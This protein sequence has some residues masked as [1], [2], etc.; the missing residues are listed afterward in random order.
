MNELT[1]ILERAAE[2]IRPADA[3]EPDRSDQIKAAE[4]FYH[5]PHFVA[6]YQRRARLPSRLVE[7][8]IDESLLPDAVRA[9]PA[10]IRAGGS[11]LLAG[12]SGSG[13]TVSATWGVR[14]TYL[15]GRVEVTPYA[16]GDRDRPTWQHKSALFARA[17][18]LYR[19]VFDRN[20]ALLDQAEQVGVLVIDDWG[21]A[22]EHA[23]P[24]GEIDTLVDVRWGER[25]P[26]IVTTN[27]H[28]DQFRKLYPRAWTRLRDA[29]GPG[30]AV[31]DRDDLRAKSRG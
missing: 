5:Q 3:P 7:L 14:Q 28:P 17:A 11:L 29:S 15:S 16:C 18:H 12:P 6:Q 30:L 2:K 20:R 9:W 31:L 26:T 27:V 4:A 10:T 8:D 19:A 23:W 21:T 25:R 24:M 1:E 22:Y 13:K